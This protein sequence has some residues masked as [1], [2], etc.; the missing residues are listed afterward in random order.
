MWKNHSGKKKPG[1]DLLLT[2]RQSSSALQAT[3]VQERKQDHCDKGVCGGWGMGVG[4]G[5]VPAA[6]HLLCKK[7][8]SQNQFKAVSKQTVDLPN[9]AEVGVTGWAEPQTKRRPSA[10]RLAPQGTTAWSPRTGQS[11]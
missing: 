10:E 11:R 7:V 5:V 3:R 1:F 4:G 2:G 8:K 6:A 9:L